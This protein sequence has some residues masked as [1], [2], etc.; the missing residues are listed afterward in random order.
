MKRRTLN[1]YFTGIFSKVATREA[2]TNNFKVNISDKYSEVDV[3]G[4]T[5][6]DQAKVSVNG[7]VITDLGVKIDEISD[8]IAVDNKIIKNVLQKRFLLV[9]FCIEVFINQIRKFSKCIAG[10]SNMKCSNKY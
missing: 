9:F 1:N 7:E 8:T 6:Y 10:V 5:G 2:G 4:T 3:I